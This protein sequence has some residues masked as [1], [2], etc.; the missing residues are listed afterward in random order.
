MGR[1]G[2]QYISIPICLVFPPLKVYQ[3]MFKGGAKGTD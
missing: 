1:T 2:C 3:E